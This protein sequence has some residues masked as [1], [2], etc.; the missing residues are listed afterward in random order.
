MRGP[1]IRHCHSSTLYWL[2]YLARITLSG[3]NRRMHVK[4]SY[5]L[6]IKYMKSLLAK[7]AIVTMSR[8]A[9]CTTRASWQSESVSRAAGLIVKP[10][11]PRTQTL[12]SSNSSAMWDRGLNSSKNRINLPKRNVLGKIPDLSTKKTSLVSSSWLEASS[13]KCSRWYPKIL[14][15]SNVQKSVANKKHLTFSM[16]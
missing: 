10:W 6:L 4:H 8:W 1:V 3:M 13:F 14:A 16:Y 15:R 2:K 11:T 7:R 12:K 9:N 5:S